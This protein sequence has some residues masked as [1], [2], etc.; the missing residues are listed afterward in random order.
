MTAARTP[1]STTLHPSVGWHHDRLT[2]DDPHTHRGE[3]RGEGLLLVPSA[4]GWPRVRKMIAPYQ[5]A[6]IYP[7]RGIATLWETAPPPATDTLAALIGRNRA[8]ILTALTEPDTTTGLATRLQ[9]TPSAISQHLSV[10]PRR[11]PRHPQPRWNVPGLVD[12]EVSC[13]ELGGSKMGSTRR[14]F[15]DEYKASA[16]AFVL[17]EGRPIAEVATK[18]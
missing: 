2:A 7:V 18:H 12:T 16:V 10:P 1:C 3:L 6:L 11:R 5:P 13:P 4:M 14:S 8:R 9:L 17:D 15:T